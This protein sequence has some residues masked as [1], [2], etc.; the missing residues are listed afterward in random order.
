MG[1]ERPVGLGGGLYCWFDSHRS[2]FELLHLANASPLRDFLLT[3]PAV[4]GL[5][6]ILC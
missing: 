1:E 2:G 6:S 4:S 5:V 3:Q